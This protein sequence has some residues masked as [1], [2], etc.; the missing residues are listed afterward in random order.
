MKIFDFM[1]ES[2]PI[3]I[4]PEFDETFNP[5][6]PSHSSGRLKSYI[7]KK[8]GGEVNCAK[9]AKVKNSPT[10]SDFYKKRASWY[11]NI[12]CK[13]K[14]QV[15]E[16]DPG[17]ALTIFDIDDTLFRTSANVIVNKPD[18]EKLPL[19]AAEFNDYKLKNGEN[20]DFEQFKDAKLFNQTSVP[21]ENVWKTTQN[22]LEN[23]GKRPGSRVVIVTARSDLNNKH[24]FLDTFEKHGLDMNKIHVFRAGN[25]KN[26]NSAQK[27]QVI[28]RRLLET[29]NFTETRLFDDHEDNLAAF[30]E[31]KQEFPEITF[32]AFP[33]GKSGKIGQPVIA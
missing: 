33:V 15:R 20:F 13:G 23:V 17:A 2:S 12:H 10:T 28:I 19:S 16:S 7:R 24:V 27:K 5:A 25:L 3:N 31:L 14:R 32:K 21:I 18:G 30:L 22:T 6:F 4:S 9:V 29:G 8:Y 11:Q 26:G 1:N